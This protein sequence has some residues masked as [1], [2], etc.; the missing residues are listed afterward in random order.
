MKFFRQNLNKIP[1][2][3]Y[4]SAVLALGALVRFVNIA[5]SSIWHDEGYTMMLVPQS[6]GSII[7]RTGR[8]VH[9]PLYYLALHLWI[10]LFGRSELAARG[11][12][13]IFS[14]ATIVVGYL[15]IRRLFNEPAARLAALFLALGPFLVRY[16]QE[17]RMYG[18]VAF[19]MVLATYCL[20]RAVESRNWAWWLGY[21]LSIAASLYTH[22]YAVFLILAHWIWMALQTSRPQAGLRNRRWWSSNIVAALLFVPW[23]PV[24]YHQFTRVQASFWIPKVSLFTLPNTLTQFMLFNDGYGQVIKFLAASLFG[25]LAISALLSARRQAR[26]MLLIIL[27]AIVGPLA[28][29]ILSFKR[30]IYVDRYFVFAA[31]AFYMLLALFVVCAWPLRHRWNLQVGMTLGLI[32]AFGFGINQ[33]YKTSNHQMRVIGQVVSSQFQP[34]DELVSGELYTYFDFTYYNHTGE[35]LKLRAPGGISGYG[36][37]SLLYDRAD[38]IVVRNYQQLHPASG[39]IWVIG[40]TGSHDYFDQVPSN[41]QAVGPHYT[42]G[43][44]AAQKYRVS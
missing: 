20:T 12:S 19:L 30:P 16:S 31:V 40:K 15:L 34:G 42:A 1:T 43:Y 38:Q 23:L 11:L 37:T 33:V 8:D 6:I 36:E 17:A 22:Y 29:F 10:G 7:A 14:L 3:W 26:G 21:S 18:M 2:G 5:K 39:Y 44:C 24:A 9:P 28:V 41:W 32:V 35:L 13:A 27:Y 25:L 4:L